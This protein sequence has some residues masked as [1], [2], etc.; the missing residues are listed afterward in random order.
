[1]VPTS[2]SLKKLLIHCVMA[3][4]QFSLSGKC[5]AILHQHLCGDTA[6]CHAKGPVPKDHPFVSDSPVHADVTNSD[7]VIAAQSIRF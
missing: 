1:M 6:S 7:P 2:N 4:G 5:L 3:S